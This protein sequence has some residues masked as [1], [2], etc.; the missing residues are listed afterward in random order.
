MAT[1]TKTYVENQ[2]S[3]N[4][5][6][7][8]VNMIGNN[9]LVN[10]ATFSFISPTVTASY[11]GSNKGYA[12]GGIYLQNLII[13]S[14]TLTP[15]FD[16]FLMGSGGLLNWPSGTTKTITKNTN[17]SIKV[18]PVGPTHTLT[19]NTADYFSSSNPTTRT[20]NV[21]ASSSA[22]AVDFL[23][24]A[25][26]GQ[27]SRYNEA[28]YDSAT[29][30]NFATI[31]LDVPPTFDASA[32]S[33]DTPYIY[34]GLTTVS[35]T[36]SNSAA[37][38]G[39]SISSVDFTI[40]N[41]TATLSGDGTLS[42]ALNAGG[43]FTP[44]VTVTDSRG[45]TKVTTFEP[46]TVNV[47]NAPTV[48]FD[49]SRTLSDG[50]PDDE[51]TYGFIEATFIFA[52][53]IADAVA[54]SVVVTDDAGTVTT[55]VV[56]WYTDAGLTTPVT[57]SSLSSG[58][59]VYG[60]FSGLST[61]HSYTVS[62]R[63]RDSEG[64]GTAV[65]QTI[66]AAFYTVDFLAGGHGIAFGKPAANVGFECAMTAKF[67]DTLQAD[68]TATFGS[69]VL[70]DLPDYQTAS[71]TDKAIYDEVVALGWDSDVLIS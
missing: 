68:G 63:P 40:G 30:N 55:P 34:A 70:I 23:S 50:T 58:D 65:T 69:D 11:S 19:L 8:T 22:Y 7:W 60:I 42:I 1:L 66:G 52:D 31:T 49:G 21:S 18:Y 2:E 37:Y 35:V 14:Q 10:G 44:T 20:L 25:D 33:Y 4:K 51:G 48:S 59:T 64:T 67:E 12:G 57:W 5:S 9:V 15:N 43:T 26:A 56:S 36:V 46:I 28:F 32:L 6:T 38:Y 24:A 62:I 41:Q 47:Y 3:S 45:Q 29:W 16:Y 17:G 39:G 27:L 13:G 53:V 71:T 54:P 61:Q